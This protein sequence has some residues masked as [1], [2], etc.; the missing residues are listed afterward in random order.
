MIQFSGA[1]IIP[2]DSIFRKN[3]FTGISFFSFDRAIIF[4]VSALIQV[5]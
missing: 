3:T 1:H 5:D 4:L 2:H